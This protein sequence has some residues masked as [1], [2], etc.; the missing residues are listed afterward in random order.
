MTSFFNLGPP[1][2]K[3]LDAS[4]GGVFRNW[5]GAAQ[6]AL[7]RAAASTQTFGRTVAQFMRLQKPSIVLL[8]LACIATGACRCRL[9]K[10]DVLK[11]GQ[12]I[13]TELPLGSTK[14]QV[15]K[16]LDDMHIEHGGRVQV[17]DSHRY[18]TLEQINGNV[19]SSSGGEP[20]GNLVFFLRDD[21]LVEWWVDSGC[22]GGCYSRRANKST[23]RPTGVN[24][25]Y[26]P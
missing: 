8:L 24:D 5:L 2:N 22:G 1:P 21:R 19:L 12:K 9:E 26:D 13:E 3:S 25:C 20:S 15:S 17:M 6:G 23:Y 10:D 11:M 16:F 18:D 4:G 7:I 14:A